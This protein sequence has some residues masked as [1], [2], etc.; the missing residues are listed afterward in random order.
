MCLVNS[1]SIKNKFL[2]RIVDHIFYLTF[3]FVYVPGFSYFHLAIV[4]PTFVEAWS[5]SHYIH[6]FIS[7]FLLLNVISN[8]IFGM[9]TETSIKGR[10]L[11]IV[12]IR[13][14]TLCSVCEC[15]CPPRSWHCNICNICILKRDHHCTFFACCIGYFNFRYF[16]YFTLYTFICNTYSLYYNVK[17]FAPFFVWNNG[18][19]ILKFVF[20]LIN[21]FFGFGYE[22][23]GVFLIVLN[24][25]VAAITGFLFIF[26]LNNVLKGRV[27]PEIK[28][29]VKGMVNKGWKSNL[30]EVFGSRWYLTWLAAFINSPLP[31]NGLEWVVDDK[32][33]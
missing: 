29:G 16:I 8:M 23:M 24:F 11:S 21:I 22:T 7:Y 14:W 17:Y 13:D 10:F 12:D 2:K 18:I 32:F 19:V 3:V 30:I 31:G 25:L 1:N 28:R 4:L 15:L 20:P 9:F 26:H 27:S 33:E 5:L 6:L